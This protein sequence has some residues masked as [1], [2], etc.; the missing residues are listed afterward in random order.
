[1]R[2]RSFCSSWR[3]IATE[4][5]ARTIV[6]GHFRD[7]QLTAKLDALHRD[8]IVERVLA[9]GD[10]REL[11]WLFGRYGREAIA[12]RMTELQEAIRRD[13]ENAAATAQLYYQCQLACDWAEVERLGVLWGGRF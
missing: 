2:C 6:L 10:R 3:A 8:L 7:E 9:F 4:C 13:P 12:A 5:P 11:R 1:M